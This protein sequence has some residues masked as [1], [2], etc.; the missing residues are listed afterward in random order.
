[1]TV[2]GKKVGIPSATPDS[3]L[4]SNETFKYCFGVHSS[5]SDVLRLD[6]A[7]QSKK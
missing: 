6:E 7:S 3:S 5:Y 1:M 2:N 4:K